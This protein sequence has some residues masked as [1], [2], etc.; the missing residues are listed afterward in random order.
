MELLAG[1]FEHE[2][3]R[4][5]RREAEAEPGG[6]ARRGAGDRAGKAAVDRAVQMA[7]EDALDLRMAG[8]DRSERLA[9]LQPGPVHA[10]DAG[11]EG[12]WCIIGKTGRAGAEASA[13]SSQAS[14]S[15][16][17]RPP[18]SPG[19]SVSRATSRTG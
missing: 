5:L 10:L 18:A 2:P 13:W 6:R 1:R 11:R 8:D 3:Q 9:V 14:R 17:N 7:A 4:R 19:I 15:E 16:H 12:G